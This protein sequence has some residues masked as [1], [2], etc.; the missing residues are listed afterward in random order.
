M[1]AR[2]ECDVIMKNMS[3]S[4]SLMYIH[5]IDLNQKGNNFLNL[6]ACLRE[7]N[8]SMSRTPFFIGSVPPQKIPPILKQQ[9]LLLESCKD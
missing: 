5:F 9:F 4:F 6:T 8:G 2:L 7:L 1:V 3:D